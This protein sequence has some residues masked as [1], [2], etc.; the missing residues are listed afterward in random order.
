M[1]ANLGNPRQLKVILCEGSHSPVKSPHGILSMLQYHVP[2]C[3]ISMD[4]NNKE[5]YWQASL[6][7]RP[8]DPWLSPRCETEDAASSRALLPQ[9]ENSMVLSAPAS[10]NDHG[11]HPEEI[12]EVMP[13]WHKVHLAIMDTRRVFLPQQYDNCARMKLEE[14]VL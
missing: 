3:V 2:L 14:E 12:C 4:K 11:H 13:D 6:L 10:K 9:Q 8:L 5:L 7:I 1:L